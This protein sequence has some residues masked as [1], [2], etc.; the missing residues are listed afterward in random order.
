MMGTKK[1][2]TIR[3]EIRDAFAAEG[4]NPIAHLDAEIR[5]AERKR[6]VDP[7]ELESLFLLRDALAKALGA[8]D[9]RQAEENEP[10]SP[11][12]AGDQGG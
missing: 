3:K 11:I 2:A 5:K 10:A 12:Q 1:P 4:I 9:R 7:A 8:G 6:K